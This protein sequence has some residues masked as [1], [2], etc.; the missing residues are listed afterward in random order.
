MKPVL[1]YTRGGGRVNLALRRISQTVR[2]SAAC[3]AGEKAVAIGDVHDKE[4]H[5]TLKAT[6]RADKQ[7]TEKPKGI[8]GISMRGTMYCV[9]RTAGGSNSEE[10]L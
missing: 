3:F 8:K 7:R 6:T 9:D 1:Q 5:S 2:R 10:H 4:H